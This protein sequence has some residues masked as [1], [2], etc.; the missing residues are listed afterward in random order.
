MSFVIVRV[1]E[2]GH[3]RVDGP[4]TFLKTIA[5]AAAATPCKTC[6]TQVDQHQ[7]L[8]LTVDFSSS[9]QQFDPFLQLILAQG[10]RPMSW[11]KSRCEGPYTSY[12]FQVSLPHVSPPTT[13]SFQKPAFVPETPPISRP[14]PVSPS[15]SLISAASS[16][17]CL[18]TPSP[19]SSANL[20]LCPG[21][22][23]PALSSSTSNLRS[24]KPIPKRHRSS[25][26]G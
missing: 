23:S 20:N 24:D 8:A 10:A 16:S 7:I 22:I 25:L 26:L 3:V 21:P 9:P 12:I 11:S 17:P 5:A 1:H 4:K 13:Q 19:A 18:S 2:S 15:V 6:S 14:N